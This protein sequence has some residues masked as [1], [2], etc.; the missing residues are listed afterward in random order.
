MNVMGMLGVIF[1][2]AFLVE[3]LVEAVFGKL[4]DNIPVLKPYSWLLAYI[5]YAVGITGAL[6]Y[7]FDILYLL[8]QWLSV[9]EISVTTFGIIITGLGIGRGSNFINDLVSKFFAK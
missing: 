8:A 9:S 7:R 5:A 2:L 4:I 1:L 3:A 6:I